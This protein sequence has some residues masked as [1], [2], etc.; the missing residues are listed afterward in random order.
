[1]TVSFLLGTHQPGWLRTAGVPLFVSEVRLRR[2]RQLPSAAAPW[3]LDSGGFSELQY[4]S[5]WIVTAEDYAA[6]VRRYRDQIGHLTWAAYAYPDTVREVELH[7]DSV[8]LAVSLRSILKLR[9]AVLAV[10]KAI[11]SA[12]TVNAF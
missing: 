2:Y 12:V 5:R 1:V 4:H 8:V 6:R 9:Q 11:G 7:V 3:A 10:P